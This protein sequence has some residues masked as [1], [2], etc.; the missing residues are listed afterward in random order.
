[1]QIGVFLADYLHM[2]RLEDAGITASWSLGLSLGEYNHLVHAG[3]LGF[4]DAWLLLDQRG[5]LFEAGA[6]GIMKSVFPIEAEVVERT[7][8]TL[9]LESRVVIGLYNAPRQQV[10][11]GDS[12]AVAR[13]VAALEDETLIQAVEIES[14]I[15][16]HAPGFARVAEGLQAALARTNVTAPGSPYVPNLTGVPVANATPEQI[17]TSLALH[18]QRPALWRASIEAVAAR[19][20]NA[21]F[22]EVGPGETLYNLFGR[23]WT[24]GRRSKTDSGDDLRKRFGALT[25]QPCHG[26]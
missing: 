6:P 20:A 8:A 7:I 24:T 3:A 22:V 10:L 21:H 11:S 25:D 14:N 19:V 15:Q 17:K 4:A 18:V 12:E 9:G 2:K 1:M 23:S 16:M 26:V 5:R 13:V